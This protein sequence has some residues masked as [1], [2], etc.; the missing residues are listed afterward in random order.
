MKA[1]LV[2]IPALLLLGCCGISCIDQKLCP[3]YIQAPPWY[4]EQCTAKGGHMQADRDTFTCCLSPPYCA[5][6]NGNYI[7]ITEPTPT[8]TPVHTVTPTPVPTP[9]SVP[10]NELDCNGSGGTWNDDE[11][12]QLCECGRE[13]IF[14]GTTARCQRCPPGQVVGRGLGP[15]FC[16]TP[17]GKEGQPCDRSTDCNGGSCM[18]VNASA[19]TGKGECHDL[20]FGCYVRI[21]GN[22]GFDPESMLCV[23]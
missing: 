18:L 11:S 14:N 13:M 21:D 20:P 22:G 4:Y 5:D 7:T 19:A 1:L 12:W 17:T 2:I 23:D 6:E 9:T 16:Y 3:M 15:A 8:P 10:P